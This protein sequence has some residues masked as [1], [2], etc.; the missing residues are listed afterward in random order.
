MVRRPTPFRSKR[1]WLFH[2]P[3][4]SLLNDILQKM[5]DIGWQLDIDKI[6]SQIFSRSKLC[7]KVKGNS[8]MKEL[9]KDDEE[10]MTLS[11]L[12]SGPIGKSNDISTGV[13]SMTEYN[14]KDLAGSES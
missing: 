14:M 7:S 1:M 5:K 2:G 6:G 4:H 9:F 10:D 11:Q 13:L 3:S 12:A 8:V